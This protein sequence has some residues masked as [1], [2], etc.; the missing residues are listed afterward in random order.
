MFC[1]SKQHTIGNRISCS[2]ISLHTGMVSNLMLYPAVPDS[3]ITFHQ[4]LPGRGKVIIPATYNNVVKSVLS[5]TLGN[6]AGDSIGTIE[7][8]MAALYGCG[9][10]N[11]NIES[12]GTEIPIMDGSAAP[13]VSLIECAGVVE[14]QKQRKIIR[15][16][17]SVEVSEGD[18]FL[19]IDPIESDDLRIN[20]LIDYDNPLINSQKITFSLLNQDFKSE[21]CNARTYGFENEVKSLREAGLALGGSLDNAVVIS[22]DKVLNKDGLR[23]RDEFVRHKILDLIGDLYLADFSIVGEIFAEKSGHNLN[24]LLL[25][26]LHEQKDAYAIDEI[27]GTYNDW[28][29]VL[30]A[31]SA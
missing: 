30:V 14:Q 1:L 13:F 25:R 18:S 31:A 11:V 19:R 23:Y 10:D 7:H 4:K 27:A 9:V 15:V 20:F 21:I 12:D 6:S 5:T 24:K 17:K 28:S 2:G 26:K 29:E 16:L 8:L 3:G 22:G